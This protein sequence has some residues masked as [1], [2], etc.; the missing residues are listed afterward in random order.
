[1]AGALRADGELGQAELSYIEE[2]DGPRMT[3][4]AD[5][6]GQRERDFQQSTIMA[7]LIRFPLDVV[8]I[9][10]AMS[11][12]RHLGVHIEHRPCRL[13]DTSRE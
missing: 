11:V 12:I 3:L 2:E 7:S 4:Q 5:P 13:Q 9:V 1:M 6:S 10:S 8:L